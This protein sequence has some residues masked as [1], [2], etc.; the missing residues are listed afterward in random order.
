[1]GPPDKTLRAA[2]LGAGLTQA[3][4]AELTGTSQA[5]IAAYESGRKEPRVTTLQRLLAAT[6][7]RITSTRPPRVPSPDQL[8]GNA[9]TLSAVLELAARLPTRH[10]PELRYPR[11]PG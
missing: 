7:H 4:L 1:M 2:R 3:A 8:A 11:L 10:A 6:G 5:T 9:R